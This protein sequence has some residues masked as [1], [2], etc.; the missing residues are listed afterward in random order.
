MRILIAIAV[1]LIGASAILTAQT[2]TS[3]SAAEQQLFAGVNRARR[4][5]ACQN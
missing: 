5:R 1:V 3:A 4:P 2:Q